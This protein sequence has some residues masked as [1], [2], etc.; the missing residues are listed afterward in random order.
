MTSTC[1]TGACARTA[2]CRYA[3]DTYTYIHTLIHTYIHTYIHTGACARTA[4]CRY[5]CIY[6]S[7]CVCIYV[8]VSAACGVQRRDKTSCTSS[9]RIACIC[10]VLCMPS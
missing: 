10:C 6:V 8:Y 1:S 4:V 2:V 3:A 9:F 5:V 7:I